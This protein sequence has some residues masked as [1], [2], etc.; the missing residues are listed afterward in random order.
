MD[1]V[2]QNDGRHYVPNIS[3][4]DTKTLKRLLNAARAK[5][6]KVRQLKCMLFEIC[7]NMSEAA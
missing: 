7:L 1:I 2:R 4:A 3:D 5:A 6:K